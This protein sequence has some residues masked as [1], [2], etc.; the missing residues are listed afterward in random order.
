MVCSSRE[1][2]ENL[3]NWARTLGFVAI[4][5]T[6]AESVGGLENYLQ[7]RKLHGLATSFEGD[8]FAERSGPRRVWPECRSVV[9]LAYPLPLTSSPQ[10]G[11]G[12]LARSAVGEDYHRILRRKLGELVELM[13]ATGWQTEVP[14]VQV[15]TG[16]LV[17]RAFALRAGV[18]WI[19][20]NQL[21]IVPGYGSFVALALLLLDQELEP[22]GSIANQCGECQRCIQACP[23]QILG[24]QEFAAIRCF[25]FLTQSKQLSLAEGEKL[26][27]RIFGCDTCQE[28]C[29][30]NR[31]RLKQELELEQRQ[32]ELELEQ[33]RKVGLELAQQADLELTEQTDLEQVQR[34]SLRRGVDL[35]E[36]LDLTKGRFN[37]KYGATAAGWRG[38]GLLQRNAYLTLRY[39]GDPRLAEW[40][41]NKGPDVPPI[42]R[43]YVA[44]ADLFKI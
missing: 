27:N 40:V 9:A 2:K 20:K 16:P 5:F 8:N 23:A 22:D 26:G 31:G 1:W 30:H 3:Q 17:E 37:E 29:P 11:E 4:G 14:R 42:M 6:S 43:G 39:L 21:L 34:V 35:L 12:V 33:R 10:P 25:S 32:Q 13:L 24:E 19:G 15:D 38:K 36:L 7:T 28:V 41:Q 18:G 44:E